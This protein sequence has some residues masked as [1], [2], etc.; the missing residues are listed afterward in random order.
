LPIWLR[1]KSIRASLLTFVPRFDIDHENWFCDVELNAD[2]APEPFMRL[3]LVRYQPYAPPEL[4]VSEPVV[5]WLQ[6]PQHRAVTVSVDESNPKQLG[7]EMKGT[8]FGQQMP[9]E[10]DFSDIRSW[11]NGSVMKVSQRQGGANM[12]A[13]DAGGIDLLLQAR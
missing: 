8:W 6:I 3:G 12:V 1:P 5:E 9:A 4:R 2:T 13:A 10:K 11:A 7:V